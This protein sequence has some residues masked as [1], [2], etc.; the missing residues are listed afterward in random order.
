MTEHMASGDLVDALGEAVL[1]TPGV[2]LLRPGIAEL[3][4][5]ANPLTKALGRPADTGGPSRSSGVRVTRGKG[6]QGWQVDV[7]VVLHRDCQ[8][9]AVTREV[10]A[11]VTATLRSLTGEPVTPRV[12][13]TVT[14]RV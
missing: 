10:R 5:A 7:H 3:L 13:V 8:A 6:A 14:G 11:A 2:A 9:V 4:R 12:S 1:S